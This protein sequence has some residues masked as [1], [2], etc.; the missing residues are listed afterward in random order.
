MQK[1]SGRSVEAVIRKRPKLDIKWSRDQSN[2][3]VFRVFDA[4]T[5]LFGIATQYIKNCI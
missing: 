5:K 2:I 1:K 4:F 3:T